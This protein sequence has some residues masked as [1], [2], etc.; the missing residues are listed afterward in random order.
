MIEKIHAKQLYV[1]AKENDLLH[2]D[3]EY[4]EFSKVSREFNRI[5]STKI[6][7]GYKFMSPFGQF[8]I[9]KRHRAKKSID[10]K[11]S[12]DK[13]QRL[14]DEGKIPYNKKDAPDGEK[15]FIYFTNEVHYYWKWIKH[16][17]IIFYHFLPSMGNKRRLGKIV[18][19]KIANQ[20]DNYNVKGNFGR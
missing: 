18:K 15:W 14:L 9:L 1:I 3:I 12:K 19:Q 11:S 20:T 2:N 4:L 17:A 10:W 13:R 8:E 16:S 6:M 5:L 7:E